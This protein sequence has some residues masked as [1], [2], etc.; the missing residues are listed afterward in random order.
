MSLPLRS[1]AVSIPEVN[2]FGRSATELGIDYGTY[3]QARTVTA[4]VNVTF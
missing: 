4:G 1:T 3:P 2:A